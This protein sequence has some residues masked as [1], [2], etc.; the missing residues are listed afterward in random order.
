MY[1][2]SKRADKAFLVLNC[3]TV[4]SDKTEEFLFGDHSVI[5]NADGGTLLLDEGS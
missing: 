1:A 2:N 3:A 4:D 5:K